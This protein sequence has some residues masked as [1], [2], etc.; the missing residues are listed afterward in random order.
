MKKNKLLFILSTFILVGCNNSLI[1]TSNNS[2]STSFN[3][4]SSSSSSTI[5][6]SDWILN[7]D[8]ALALSNPNN[9]VYSVDSNLNTTLAMEYEKELYFNYEKVN[10]ANWNSAQLF[11]HNSN[12]NVGNEYNISLSISSSHAGKITLNGEV[13]ELNAGITDVE[14]SNV[15]QENQATISMQFGTKETGILSE[16]LEV[17]ISSFKV[18][19]KETAKEII[20]RAI[21]AN[22]YTITLTEGM[23]GYTV[24]SKFFEK[25]AHFDWSNS[26]D[27]TG[28]S[29]GYAENDTAVFGFSIK[30]GKVI[31]NSN[32][33]YDYE[34]ESNVKGLYTSNYVFTYSGLEGLPSLHKLDLSQFDYLLETGESL[35]IN[36][37]SSLKAL[38]FMLDD[39]YCTYYYGGI[40]STELL[41]NEDGNLEF[42][43]KTKMGDVSKFLLSNIGTTEEETIE[44]FIESKNFCPSSEISTEGDPEVEAML[45]DINNGNYSVNK[46]TY[47][48]FYMNDRYSY[49]VSIDSDTG[50]EVITGYIKLS[51]GVYSY[52]VKDSIVVLGDNYTSMYPSITEINHLAGLS[53]GGVTYFNDASKYSKNETEGWFEMVPNDYSHYTFGSKWYGQT[54]LSCDLVTLERGVSNITIG[55][56]MSF[57]DG[58]G[59]AQDSLMVYL[60]VYSIGNTTVEFMESYL[61]S[62]EA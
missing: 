27:G 9:W 37:G 32:Y 20:Q 34:T 45:S 50:E 4:S 59:E 42:S 57:A 35:K 33:F 47:G 60:V 25:A 44:A 40:A 30:D 8:E 3:T 13:V 7:G 17:V 53:A 19:K 12:V 29:I 21:E 48:S 62:L 49:D 22:N 24:T 11:Y 51:D 52:S 38:T 6:T 2:S 61:A 36:N 16:N 10:A 23:N 39:F 1:S 18:N 15:L 58:S 43:I 41:L 55:T 26:I 28:D 31:A 14:L 54:S 56:N 5:D 46:G